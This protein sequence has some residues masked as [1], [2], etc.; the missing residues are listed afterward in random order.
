MIVKYLVTSEDIMAGLVNSRVR[1]AAKHRRQSANLTFVI[2]AA[3]AAIGLIVAA[4]A[5]THSAGLDPDQVLSI[6]AAP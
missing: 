1:D 3:T 2:C 4:Y 5:M 6:F